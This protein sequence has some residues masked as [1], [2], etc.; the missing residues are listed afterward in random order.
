MM[1]LYAQILAG[2]MSPVHKLKAQIIRDYG[3]NAVCLEIALIS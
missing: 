3:N 1:T 2:I